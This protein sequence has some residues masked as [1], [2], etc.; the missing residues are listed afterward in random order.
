MRLENQGFGQQRVLRDLRARRVSSKVAD[1]AVA[2][3]FAD[4]NEE[5]LIDNFLKRKFRRVVLSE[6]LADPKHVA[7]AYRKL[8]LAGFS[9]GKS[10]SALK[11]YA[12]AA[13]A[14]EGT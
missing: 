4:S 7:S 14:L 6:Y 5:Q 12:N 13:E 11:R 10:I 1:E 9:S 3:A 8:R 2:G